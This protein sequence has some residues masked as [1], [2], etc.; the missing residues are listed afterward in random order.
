[1]KIA[2]FGELFNILDAT[3]IFPEPLARFY[4]K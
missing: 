2:V 4:F 3:T 1:M